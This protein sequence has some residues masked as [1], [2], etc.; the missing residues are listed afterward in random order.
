MI[1]LQTFVFPTE[2]FKAPASLYLR[3]EQ[4]VAGNN[5]ADGSLQLP[6]GKQVTFDTYFNGLSVKQWKNHCN[7]AELSL[8][9]SG[10]G[11]VTARIGLHSTGKDTRILS[12]QDITLSLTGVTLEIPAWSDIED[13]ILY[14]ELSAIDDTMLREAHFA[15]DTKPQHDVKLGIVVTHFN[16]KHYVLP[17]IKR[18][19]EQLLN[20]PELRDVIDLVVVDNS[21]NI[22]Q[23][24][25]G[26]AILIA[27]ANLGGSGGFTRGLLH[28]IDHG[29]SHCLFMDDDASCEIES[30]RRTYRLLQFAK[31]TKLAVAGGLLRQEQP[32]ILHE[33]GGTYQN[34]HWRTAQKTLDTTDVASLLTLD[35]GGQK[36]IDYGAWW[37]FGFKISEVAA[38]P[39]PFF[40]RGDDI[41]FGLMNDFDIMT[42]SGIGVWGEDFGYKE[43]NSTRYLNTRA[44][45]TLALLNPNLRPAKVE[46]ILFGRAR[47]LLQSYHYDGAVAMTEAIEDV[48]KGPQFWRD[49][50]DMVAVRERLKQRCPNDALQSVDLNG[51]E[52]V[53]HLTLLPLQRVL[54]KISLN[55]FLLPNFMI[56]D[57][58]VTIKKTFSGDLN[59]AFMNKRLHYVIPEENLGYRTEYD[60]KRFFAVHKQLRQ[61]LSRLK[62]NYQPLQE[63]YLNA[64]PA[65]TSEAFWRDVY[66]DRLH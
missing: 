26:K 53:D 23:D 3:A 65:M 60:K 37:H 48:M 6:A 42:I 43:S 28:L 9:L 63:R 2:E 20:D 19:S 44:T 17:A 18:V 10:A 25:A 59:A 34:G 52:I 57:R 21:N 22:T 12:E 58:E 36:H 62:K 61:T 45:L 15:T 35:Q 39:F 29:Y 30:L 64:L 46:S 5:A 7:I 50:I 56:K 24:E 51:V 27:N 38:F 16:R 11:K 54:R 66:K 40:V 32:E 33:S 8:R 13:G 4:P 55:G 41:L 31:E 1:K 14:L 49:E 47:S